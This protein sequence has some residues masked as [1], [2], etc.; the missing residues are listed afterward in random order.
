MRRLRGWLVRWRGLLDKRRQDR[1]L[2]EELE[3]HVQM[4]VQDNLERGMTPEEARREALVKLGGIE[5]TKENYRDRR[6][7]PWLES[8]LQ[9]IRFG[10]RILRKNPGF[11]AVAVLTLALGIGATT[12]IF[13]AAY[14]TL[15]A[16]LPYP[17][18][19]Q[20]VMVW[21][22]LQGH[23]YR[24]S[25]GDFTD[26]KRQSTMFEDLNAWG[27]D[28]FNIATQDRPEYFDGMAA[29]QGYYGM[30]GNPL[31]LGRNFFPEE[32]EPGKDHVVILTY[33]LWRHLGANREIIGRTMQING[34]PYT[35][36]GVLA[37][38]TAD[39]WDWELIIPLVL[40]PEQLNDH[41]SRPWR[42]T[43]R[44][45]P[46]VTIKQAQAEMD[47][48]AA[49][50]ANDHP[51]SNQG[52]GA[53][54]EPLKNDF[55][56]SGRKTTLWLLLAAVGFLLLIACLNVA[57]LLLARGI[58]RQRE[59]AIRA[60]VG[61]KPVAIFAQFLTESLV[62]AILGGLLGVAMGYAMLWGLVAVIPPHALPAEAD[63]R[64][65]V[66][67]LLFMLAATTLS[68]VLFGCAPAWY[69]SRLDPAGVLKEGGG[70]GVGVGR[71]RLRSVFVI[72][73]FAL[74][75]PLLAGAGLAIHSFWNLTHV[76]LGVRTD[77]ILGFYVDSVALER[78]GPLPTGTTNSYYRRILASI[79]E[80]PG[81]SN[82]CAMSY[83]PL[84]SLHA[85]MPFTIAGKPIYANPALRPSADL[86][87]VTPDYFQ[88]FGIRIVK[89]RA[90]TDADNASSFRV[91][92]VNETFADRFLKG[93]D[94][95]QQRV[96][97]EQVR[98]DEETNGPAV[99]W[100]IVGVFHTVKSRGARD[101]NPEIDTPFWQEA[102]SVSGIG[103]R[104]AEDPATMVKSIAAAVN[105]VDP[106]AALALTRTMEQVHDEVLANDRFTAILF[107]SFAVVALLL[108]AVGIHGV[109]AFSAT[110]RSHEIALR[111]A[112]G[113]TRNGVVALVV[114]EGLMLACLGLGLG[115]I[116]AYF[117][118]RA[119]QSVL[120]GVGA[121]DF[122][123]L[124]AVALVLLFAALMAC[125][126]PARRA[127]RVDPMVALRHE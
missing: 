36:V 121:I 17:Q 107:A 73:E 49:K 99:E 40:K 96:V 77:H 34:E 7:F 50:E 28:N 75:L 1:E 83:L 111:L 89:G 85:E 70:L 32:G 95:L 5:Q 94:P 61:A 30:L 72:A 78:G 38:G 54:V 87:M 25:S 13:T 23:R 67:I 126:L 16:P 20:L 100:Q 109:V 46:G 115:V 101:D 66:S 59:V 58:T 6:G 45:K 9:D 31:L 80:V 81:V 55:L 11:T 63:L 37:S 106:Q 43:G 119:M 24:V 102:F 27:T 90:F 125:Y 48:I 92:M 79:G 47:A 69:A 113:A 22:K 112:L 8:R 15:L 71:R 110:Q 74:S 3:S 60:S 97:M 76:D 52:W 51:K 44:L 98:P 10:L 35:V 64:L 114:K 116:G 122:S 26:W 19:N 29:T 117:V 18:P 41:D 118:G 56:P 2:A 53:L 120:F 84:D 124:D 4:H 14:A 108:A 103:V 86:E 91:A 93:V 127:A 105:T 12:A 88:T 65:N 42:V 123:T 82:V 21:S 57:N 39:R 68:G 104:T 62:L 33:R